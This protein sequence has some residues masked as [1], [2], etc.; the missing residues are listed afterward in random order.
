MSEWKWPWCPDGRTLPA[1]PAIHARL[2]GVSI[3]LA[4]A[5]GRAQKVP[6]LY[7]LVSRHREVAVDFLTIIIPQL[8]KKSPPQYKLMQ[9]HI[10]HDLKSAV[11]L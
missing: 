4:R 1:P 2:T 7:Q 10:L 5:V 9:A 8:F 11:D 3:S 6:R